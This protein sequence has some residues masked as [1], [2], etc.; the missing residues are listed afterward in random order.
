MLDVFEVQT[1]V[2]LEGRILPGGDLPQSG[3]ARFHF[4]AAQVFETV[5]SVVVERVRARPHQAHIALHDVPELGQF[6]DA[7]PA[8]ET[9]EG[10]DP[11]VV[12]DFEAGTLPFVAAAE[13][14]FQCIGVCDHSAE[15]VEG[16]D[17]SLL[18]DA[19]RAIENRT[20]G[21][22]L[23]LYSDDDKDRQTN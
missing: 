5:L 14:F 1:H 18:S 2:G 19:G 15:F 3:D 13:F 20:G 12:S 8:Q 6:V 7:V 17:P 4:E 22:E 11:R 23:D 21:I 16:E 10:R 9:A